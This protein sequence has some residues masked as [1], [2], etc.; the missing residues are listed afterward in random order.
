MAVLKTPIGLVDK[1]GFKKLEREFDTTRITKASQDLTKIRQ[2]MA[3]IDGWVKEL[4]K[5]HNMAMC[6]F[7]DEDIRVPAGSELI[8][9]LAYNMLDELLDW[10]EKIDDTYDMLEELTNLAPDPDDCE[11]TNDKD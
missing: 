9:E 10:K 1:D 8:H 5:L 4:G 2:Q 3:D 6:L 11:D 7:N